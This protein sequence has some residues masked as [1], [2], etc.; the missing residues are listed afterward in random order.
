MKVTQL[1]ATRKQNDKLSIDEDQRELLAAHD[2]LLFLVVF[3]APEAAIK[4]DGNPNFRYI[5]DRTG[6]CHR[7]AKARWIK[8]QEKARSLANG[9]FELEPP[10]DPKFRIPKRK[11][12]IG[13]RV[14]RK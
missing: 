11:G 13:K 2:V 14:E 5:M 7:T 4:K 8:F 1:D 12:Y 10:L 6:W 3:G 9:T